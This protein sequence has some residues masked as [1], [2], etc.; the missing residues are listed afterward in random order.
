MAGC[1][2]L[3]EEVYCRT[4]INYAGQEGPEPVEVTIYNAR[5]FPGLSY[6]RN[7]FEL[8]KFPSR[9][10]DWLDAAKIEDCHYDEVTNWAQARF[11]CDAVL[12]YPVLLRN[13]ETQTADSDYAPIHFAHSDYTEAYGAMI[14][15]QDR[16]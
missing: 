2:R 12:Y 5:E 6:K 4:S 3:S 11:G 7:G 9:V 8:Q 1:R 15:Q 16:S 14:G 10:N 13:P